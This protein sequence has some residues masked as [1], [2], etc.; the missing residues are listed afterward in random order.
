MDLSSLDYRIISTIASVVMTL[1]W[2]AYLHLALTQ[3]MRAN[4]PFLVIQHAH[5]NDP[6]A[7]CLFV[8]LSKEP[9]HLQAVMAC[10]HRGDER[11]SFRIT[12]YERITATE[13]NVQSKLR[14]GPIQPGGYLVL[15]SFAD[16]M[17]G[18]QSE[19]EDS[20]KLT[21]DHLSQ[22][23]SLELCVAVVYAS[24]KYH[25]GARRHFF[26]E[27]LDGNTKIHAY[28]IFTE[29]LVHRKHRRTVRAWVNAGVDPWE[30]QDTADESQSQSGS[31]IGKKQS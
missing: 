31:H 22:I 24:K 27:H 15:G 14:Q 19:D 8:N 7:L 23:D 18:N 9:V 6:S 12:N 3:Y 10:V 25:I 13:Q 11:T 4:R 28:S 16:I 29:Q 30:E 20:E 21:A 5:E 1:A 26:L 2:V 17:L